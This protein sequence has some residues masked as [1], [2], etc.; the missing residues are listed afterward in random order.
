MHINT[1]YRIKPEIP[2]MIIPRSEEKEIQYDELATL[3]QLAR[4]GAIGREIEISCAAMATDLEVSTQTASRRLRQLENADLIERERTNDGQLVA[5]NPA[6]IKAL[7]QEYEEY[8]E[9]F[10][11]H[12]TIE[13]TG[14]AT[15]GMG[16]GRHFIT[17]PGYMDQF[18]DRLGYEPFPGTF[19]VELDDEST[20]RRSAIEAFQPIPIDSWEDGDNT[21]GAASCYPATIE[22]TNGNRYEPAHLLVPDR[23]DHTQNQLEIVAPDKLRDELGL[24][25]GDQVTVHVQD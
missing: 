14:E 13:L 21:Y 6:G 15:S 23:T 16:R 24:D 22:A 7:K 10:A 3:K 1:G 18:T 25:D 5:L 19:N 2:P 20:Q 12:S 4:D 11:V 8:R 17:L 9:I